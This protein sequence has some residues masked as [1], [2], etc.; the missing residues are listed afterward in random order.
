MILKITLTIDIDDGMI[1]LND[2]VQEFWLFEEVLAKEQLRLHSNEIGDEV[3]TITDV[4]FVIPE[5][6]K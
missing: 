6:L 1:D 5:A 3:G 4:S 2:P